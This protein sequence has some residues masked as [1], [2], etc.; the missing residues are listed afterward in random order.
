MGDD[1]NNIGLG[2]KHIMQS[3]EASLK[4]LQT[5]YIDLYQVIRHI[6]VQYGYTC[7]IGGLVQVYT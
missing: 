6:H 7:T 1:V 2:R 4:R 5:D 3:C